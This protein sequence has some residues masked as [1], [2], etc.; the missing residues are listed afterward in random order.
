MG[1]GFYAT[2]KRH[3]EIL[4]KKCAYCGKVIGGTKEI[5]KGQAYHP[6]CW[7]KKTGKGGGW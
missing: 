5:H 2:V 3:K 1:T 6:S 7:K 4:E